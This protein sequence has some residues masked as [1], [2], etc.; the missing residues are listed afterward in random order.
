MRKALL[1]S[2]LLAWSLYLI[3]VAHKRFYSG[4]DGIAGGDTSWHLQLHYNFIVGH[5]WEMSHSCYP[6]SSG[7]FR[8]GYCNYLTNHVFLSTLLLVPL[9]KMSDSPFTFEAF[10]IFFNVFVGSLFLYKLVSLKFNNDKQI[11]FTAILL[12]TISLPVL[13]ICCVKFF[14]PM[15]S[16]GLIW[17]ILYAAYK[18]NDVLYWVGFLLLLGLEEDIAAT[19]FM[20]GFFQ[21]F[22]GNKKRGFLSCVLS[23]LYFIAALSVQAHYRHLVIAGDT[24]L[25]AHFFSKLAHIFSDIAVEPRKYLAMQTMLVLFL[26]TT[27]F[28]GTGKISKET[29]GLIM[30]SIP[31]LLTG[32]LS[33]QHHLAAAVPLLL[34][35]NLVQFHEFKDRRIFGNFS[36]AYAYKYYLLSSMGFFILLWVPKV[37]LPLET[38]NRFIDFFSARRSKSETSPKISETQY[39]NGFIPK[40]ATL[41]YCIDY[42]IEP[43]LLFGRHSI[44]VYPYL[45]GQSEYFVEDK[46]CNTDTISPIYQKIFQGDYYSVYRKK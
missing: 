33:A 18:G 2:G 6:S 10:M 4:T 23:A 35:A 25:S 12:Y 11:A 20:L 21:Y 15:L 36:V 44:W 38:R 31:A 46:S 27:P 22:S 34:L 5:S 32:I 1:L 41:T 40:E 43:Y 3:F 42:A 14:P 9:L 13:M 39:I 28:L 29:S 7:N 45:L 17:V 30:A 19:G 37:Y 8:P 16:A 24:V 26:A